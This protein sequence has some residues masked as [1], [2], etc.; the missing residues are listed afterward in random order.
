M[1]GIAKN[2][3]YGGTKAF[4]HSFMRGVAVEQAAHGVRANCVCPGPIDTA[5]THKS[6]GPMNREMEFHDDRRDAHG[7]SRHAGRGRECL[8][9]PRFR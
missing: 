7:S 9:L 2:T 5:W 1:I 6:S 4:I 8:L 3:M